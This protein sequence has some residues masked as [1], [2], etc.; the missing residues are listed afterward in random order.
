MFADGF[1]GVELAH[2]VQIV[3]NVLAQPQFARPAAVRQ[4]R[5]APSA[6]R[7]GG[8]LLAL[9]ESLRRRNVHGRRYEAHGEE[10]L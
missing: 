2:G 8:R 4:A 3:F 1:R 9:D 6:R 7:G 5:A 10:R